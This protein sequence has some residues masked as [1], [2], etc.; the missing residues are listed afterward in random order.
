MRPNR[1]KA[2]IITFIIV[3]V[4]LIAGYFLVVKGG[5]LKNDSSIIG[6]KFSP[7]LGTP[8]EK[9][10]IVG[11]NIDVDIPTPQTD[12]SQTDPSVGSQTPNDPNTTG[13]GTNTTPGS[14]NS[15]LPANNKPKYTPPNLSFPTPG[16][17]PSSPA[18]TTNTTVVLA[19]CEDGRD[20]DGDGFIDAKDKDCHFDGDAQNTNSYV[21]KDNTELGTGISGTTA[22]GDPG[23]NSCDVDQIPLKFTPE[24]QAR[25]NELTR[26]FYRLASSLKTENDIIAEIASREGYLDTIENAKSLTLQCRAQTSTPAYLQNDG[27]WQQVSSTKE[28]FTDWKKDDGVDDGDVDGRLPKDVQYALWYHAVYQ[29]FPVQGWLM[30][31]TNKGRTERLRNPYYDSSREV[32][33][34]SESISYYEYYNVD[35]RPL[36]NNAAMWDWVDFEKDKKVW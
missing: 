33:P 25:L 27:V 34:F 21:P 9:D 30:S 4:L 11:D 13:S 18:N 12:D 15:G 6:K 31:I 16:S 26:E 29:N 35:P 10:T 28:L 20:N 14:T 8:K 19:Q 3:L 23:K 1:S 36:N 32:Y 22:T 24:E 2:F 5:V 7:L 17:T